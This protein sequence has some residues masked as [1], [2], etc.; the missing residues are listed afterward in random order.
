MKNITHYLLITLL[1]CS[2]KKMD[3]SGFR[4]EIKGEWE[5]VRFSGFGVPTPALPPG[6]GRI[7]EFGGDGGFKR[8]QHD[9]LLFKGTYSLQKKKDCF[10]EEKPVFVQTNDANFTNGYIVS[11]IGDNLFISSPNCFVDGGSAIYRKL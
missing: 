4:D 9:T 7:I 10:G 3:F 1:A 6:N 11:R 2:C 5:Y 8:R